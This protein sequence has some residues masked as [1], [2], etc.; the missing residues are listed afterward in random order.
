MTDIAEGQRRA[1][2]AHDREGCCTFTKALTDIRAGRFFA[3]RDQ[4]IRA[5]NVLIS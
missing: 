4:I 1:H 2:F 3:D 5:Q